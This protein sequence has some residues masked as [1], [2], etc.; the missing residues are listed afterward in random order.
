MRT[1][2]G[3]VRTVAGPALLLVA[4]LATPPGAAAQPACNPRIT[5]NV[6]SSQECALGG[7]DA[8]FG[9]TSSGVTTSGNTVTLPQG[10]VFLAPSATTQGYAANAVEILAAEPVKVTT[11][12]VVTG[13]AGPEQV[14][15]FDTITVA[16]FVVTSLASNTQYL[17]LAYDTDSVIVAVLAGSA[18]A[19]LD[20]LSTRVNMNQQ[21]KF[22]G[23]G[24]E[25]NGGYT[26]GSLGPTV[27]NAL[28]G[29]DVYP[30]TNGSCAPA[31]A[32]GT[33]GASTSCALGGYT[34]Y[35]L[36]GAGGTIDV[37]E[38]SITLSAGSAYV[39]YNNTAATPGIVVTTGYASSDSL[40][41]DPLVVSSN[42]ISGFVIGL[43][44]A[45]SPPT[46]TDTAV[47][48]VASG[49]V[50]TSMQGATQILPRGYQTTYYGAGQNRLAGR[51]RTAISSSAVSVLRALNVPPSP[52]PLCP[53]E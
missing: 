10:A 14:V 13:T 19:A 40:G 15:S 2:Y 42:G 16:T 3:L 29:L 5:V 7:F 9:P 52:L 1:P 43:P 46:G 51:H 49:S 33:V 37:S 11:K 41:T 27:T 47:V 39:C 23:A 31:C 36:S 45:A 20:T 35:F 17:V 44:G 26:I 32:N 6:G 34:A 12:Y 22:S 18:L 8:T 28:C 4:S 24:F 38:S 50:T 53:Q 25:S 21:V 30:S 48:A